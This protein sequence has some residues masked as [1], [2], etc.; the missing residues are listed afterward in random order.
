MKCHC[1]WRYMAH[2]AFYSSSLAL[3]DEGREREGKKK[4]QGRKNRGWKAE[5][6]LV[7][8]GWQRPGEEGRNYLLENLRHGTAG[9]LSI[10]ERTAGCEPSRWILQNSLFGGLVSPHFGP[11]SHDF[12]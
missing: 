8:L 6:V 4:G 2:L 10:I 9:L 5:S 3:K 12:L 11:F 7:A 1:A